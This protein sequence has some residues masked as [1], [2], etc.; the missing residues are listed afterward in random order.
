LKDMDLLNLLIK[1]TVDIAIEKGV[2]K[3]RT[4]IVDYCCPLKVEKL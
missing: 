2:I 3:S 1:K 4:I